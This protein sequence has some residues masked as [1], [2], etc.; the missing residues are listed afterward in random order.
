MQC[1]YIIC[2]RYT[3]GRS[4]C[5]GRT[6]ALYVLFVVIVV[7]VVAVVYIVGFAD[8]VVVIV[9]VTVVGRC[10]YC[11]CCRCDCWHYVCGC[12]CYI[13]YDGG[14]RIFICVAGVAVVVVGCCVVW[15]C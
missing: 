3:G 2:R 10:C 12:C 6:P 1:R 7:V 8:V 13:T 9:I 4:T 14:C 5:H 15:L 11:C